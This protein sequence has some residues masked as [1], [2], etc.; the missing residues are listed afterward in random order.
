MQNNDW[1]SLTFSVGVNDVLKW[2]FVAH[3]AV[4]RDSNIVHYL[5]L[6]YL[7]VVNGFVTL[8][9]QN[10]SVGK[11]QEAWQERMY[12][13]KSGEMIALKIWF[14]R[15][16]ST[17]MQLQYR[18]KVFICVKQA[19]IEHVWKFYFVAQNWKNW[20]VKIASF[21]KFFHQLS[22]ARFGVVKQVRH[23][24]ACIYR[25]MLDA[26]KLWEVIL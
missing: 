14:C 15:C 12:F 10:K 19:G 18:K 3:Q 23:K 16:Q 24:P 6:L 13:G 11:S 7:S 25:D 8:R 22:Q 17:S 26:W 21:L 1:K 9:S 5:R 4:T 2:I 20:K